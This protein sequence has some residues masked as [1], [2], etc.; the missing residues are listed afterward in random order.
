MNPFYD[1]GQGVLGHTVVP[2][3][4]SASVS[5][6]GASWK[7]NETD[8]SYI[9]RKIF[10]LSHRRQGIRLMYKFIGNVLKL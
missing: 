8:L 7:I 5:E 3:Q 9:Q 2:V 6:L 1:F 10:G 4:T